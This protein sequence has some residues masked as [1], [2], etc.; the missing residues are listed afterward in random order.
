MSDAARIAVKSIG[1]FAPEFADLDGQGVAYA[2][3]YCY[4]IGSHGCSRKSG[5]FK[6]SAFLL[7]RFRVDEGGRVAGRDGKPTA[8]GAEP[9]TYVE[10]TY[11]VSEAL[12][13]APQVA[14]F[15]GRSCDP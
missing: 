3:P 1:I 7:V 8:A 12:R 14:K 5:K 10:I 9:A 13:K 4:V 11:P 15:F 2:K 6:S